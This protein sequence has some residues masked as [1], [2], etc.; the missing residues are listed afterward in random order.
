M[1]KSLLLCLSALLCFAPLSTALAADSDA[2][3]G[4]LEIRGL[5]TL[6]ASAFELSK[7]G[8]QPVPKEMASIILYGALGSMPGMGI[9]PNGT[10][11][12]LWLDNGTDK[13]AVALLLP[14]E[15]EGAD[16]LAGLGQAGWKNDSE[17]AEG[18][19][20]FTAPDTGSGTLWSEIYF[21]KRGATLVAAQTADDVRMA[22]EAM[23]ALPPILPAE[24]DVV[25][26]IRP[27]ALMEVFGPQIQEQMDQ[28]FQADANTPPEAQAMGKLYVKG[29]M[30]LA[31]QLADFSLG[32]GVAD[33]NLNFHTRLGPVAD[34]TLAAWLGSMK[35]PSA[36]ASVVN[37]P[38][39]LYAQTAHLGDLSLIAP[40]Y[41]R[42]VE[43]VLAL[44]PAEFDAAAIQTY[45]A[46]EKIYLA[47]MG[48]DFGIA[49]LTP[50][51]EKPVRLVEYISLKDTTGLR[52][53][54]RQM[55]QSSSAMM[56][57]MTGA[58]SAAMPFALSLT[59]G[60]PRTYRDIAVDT[61][62]YRLEPNA[63][64]A[65]MWPEGFPTQ[66]DI[67]LAW[68]PGGLL[69][70]VGDPALTEAMVDRALDGAAAPLAALPAWKAAYPMPEKDLVDVSHFALFETLRSY[71][72]VA[73]AISGGEMA[74][75]IPAGPGNIESAS[76]LAMGGLMS[77]ARF[78][79][80]DIGAIGQKAREAQEKAMA[81]QMEM[82]QQMQGMDM[83]GSGDASFMMDD[84]E[85][86]TWDDAG[87]VEEAVEETDG[88]PL[89]EAPAEEAPAPAAVE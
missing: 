88:E 40:A 33:G 39:A 9:Q 34:T 63:Q 27:A 42:Y 12:A 69:A 8:G 30:A 18:I 10:V 11:R 25:V 55:L 45:L 68:I 87:D 79:L 66:F 2:V 83:D 48:G 28:A 16:Y 23:P 59:P 80:A 20:H 73:D 56:A 53:L 67:E 82:M 47:Q 89:E 71:L 64:I 84:Y 13:G 15:N 86:E 76:Y 62:A 3:L 65:A 29:Y 72:G 78:S 49:L 26:Q 21:L 50:T 52:D 51:K 38:G 81:A 35:S 31:R 54:T 6:A 24:G 37:L 32:L 85:S 61:V 41:F 57:A 74:A 44:L 14:V 5:D 1:K 77:R 17:T 22:D 43:E 7:A 75:N 19:E 4:I 60:E 70:S 58:N 46:N 36:A